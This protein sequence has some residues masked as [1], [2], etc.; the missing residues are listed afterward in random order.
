[1]TDIASS[2]QRI[3][4]EEAAYRG[5]VSENL[6]SRLG[7]SINALLDVLLPVGSVVPTF[8]TE[9]QYQA[10]VGNTK[11]VLADGRSSAGTEFATLTGLTTIPDLRGNGLRGKNNGRVDGN[12][13]PAGEQPLGT[14]E[15][16]QMLVHN[17]GFQVN[18]AIGPGGPIPAYATG[19]ST[20][21]YTYNAGTGVETRIKST[22]VN[23]MVRIN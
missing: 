17:H 19:P 13:N 20:V 1:M 2:E 16:D 22:C 18:S 10:E 9:A 21:D 4:V 15:A 12:Q 14:Y 5:P 11:W 6:A 23:F 7:A 3:Q 8:L